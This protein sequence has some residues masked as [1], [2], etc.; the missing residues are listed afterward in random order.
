[1]SATS[2]PRSGLSLTSSLPASR[3]KSRRCYMQPPSYVTLH[4]AGSSPSYTSCQHPP[5]SMTSMSLPRSCLLYLE[6][7]T[8]LL[9]L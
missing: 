2:C 8:R 4:T 3:L 1:S 9:L 6:T 5:S 7:P